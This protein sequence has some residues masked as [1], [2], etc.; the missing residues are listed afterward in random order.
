MSQCGRRLRVVKVNEDEDR[1]CSDALWREG[2][3]SSESTAATETG[4]EQRCAQRQTEA[5]FPRELLHSFIRVYINYT[6]IYVFIHPHFQQTF[7]ECPHYVS[8]SSRAHSS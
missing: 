8:L 4:R 5:F 1:V 7:A 3:R 6:C 2:D